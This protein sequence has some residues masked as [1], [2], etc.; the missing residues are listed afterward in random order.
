VIPLFC[1]VLFQRETDATRAAAVAANTPGTTP[2]ITGAA[3]PSPADTLGWWRSAAWTLRTFAAHL[4]WIVR[5]TVPLMV[6]AGVLGSILITAVPWDVLARVAT[7]SGRLRVLT[8]MGGLAALA[9]FLPVPMAFDVV[10]SDILFE[11]GL[12]AQYVMVLLF[13]LGTFSVYPFM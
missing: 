12:P 2:P 13:T 6:L 3:D 7:V 5:T 10:I 9:T 4:W 1:R 8:A 11:R